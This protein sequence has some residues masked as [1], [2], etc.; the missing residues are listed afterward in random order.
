MIGGAQPRPL[1]FDGNPNRDARI[2]LVGIAPQEP[3]DQSRD[4]V[5]FTF[6][7][8]VSQLLPVTA[9]FERFER[10]L[11][12]DIGHVARRHISG[13]G[14]YLSN[15]GVFST[16]KAGSKPACRQDCRPHLGSIDSYEMSDRTLQ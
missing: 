1:R 2:L 12:G 7:H 5:R 4:S 10:R 9:Q 11:Y 3:P 16:P 6:G 13:Q 8:N 14:L 15:Q